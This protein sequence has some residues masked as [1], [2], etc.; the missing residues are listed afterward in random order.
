MVTNEKIFTYDIVADPSFYSARFSSFYRK[1]K[2]LYINRLYK[3]I[4]RIKKIKKLL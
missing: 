4:L 1:D 2:I 3:K